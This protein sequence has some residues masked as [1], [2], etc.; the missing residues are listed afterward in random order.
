MKVESAVRRGL[1]WVSFS[2]SARQGIEFCTAL[3]LAALLAPEDFGVFAMA[4]LVIGWMGMVRDLGFG[5]ALIHNQEEIE[6]SA[7]TAF[8]LITGTAVVL[9]AGTWAVSP[10]AARFFGTSELT[11]VLRVLG[12]SFIIISLRVVQAT[13]LQK[14]LNFKKNSIPPLI[15]SLAHG[16][17]CVSLALLGYGVWSIVV[18]SLFGNALLTVHYWFISPFRPRLRFKWQT[19]RR[20]V[21]YGNIAL[22]DNIL[23]FLL[24]TFD[25]AA[26]GRILGVKPLGYYDFAYRVANLPATRVTRVVSNVMFPVYSRL[27]RDV[28]E[29]KQTYLQTIRYLAIIVVPVSAALAGLGPSFAVLL[30]GGKWVPALGALRILV[31][32]GVTTGIGAPA[33]TVL[34]A[35]GRP[36]DSL[37]INAI[38]GALTIGFIYHSAVHGGI[39]GV[40]ALFATVQVVATA[41][42]IWRAN[43]LLGIEA[44]DYLHWLGLPAGCTGAAAIMGLALAARYPAILQ[45][46]TGAIGTSLILILVY[47]LLLLRCDGELRSVGSRVWAVCQSKN[48]LA[49][50]RA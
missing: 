37:T 36:R 34:Y 48:P 7:H 22:L 28:N 33:A 26:I 29:L 6:E 5:A 41:L 17:V 32:Y 13:M 12:F 21:G 31:I 16:I 15:S 20:L 2:T 35:L 3:F 8:T 30:Y 45:S 23:I 11:A 47:G 18:G 19:A 25:R 43:R 1:F 10:I 40:A 42:L 27:Q 9:C 46:W 49:R 44:A 39:I 4:S 14:N 24:M 38:K 50:S